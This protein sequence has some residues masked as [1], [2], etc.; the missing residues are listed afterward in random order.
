MMACEDGPATGFVLEMQEQV[1][2]TCANCGEPMMVEFRYMQG[3]RPKVFEHGG[4]CNNCQ[5]D[6]KR[7][8]KE[9]EM[10]AEEVEKK[11]G[12]ITNQLRVMDT[13]IKT[14]FEVQSQLINHL[15]PVSRDTPRESLAKDQQALVPI[16]DQLAGFNDNLDNLTEGLVIAIENLEI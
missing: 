12:Q 8:T 7:S 6:R 14:L 11:V 15:E 1:W 10:E 4:W 16:A 9:T 3:S 13:K 2:L 5:I